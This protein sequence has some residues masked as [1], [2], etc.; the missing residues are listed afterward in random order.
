VIQ[1]W[2]GAAALAGG[3][4]SGWS[5]LTEHAGART[6]DL[7]IK[8]PLLYQLSYVLGLADLS[9]NSHI[10]RRINIF[11]HISR[12]RDLSTHI[13][14][15]CSCCASKGPQSRPCLLG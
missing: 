7:R 11:H 9:G 4:L 8:S 10:S 12:D 6:Q 2:R 5:N 14:Q 15:C 1:T 3:R 13:H